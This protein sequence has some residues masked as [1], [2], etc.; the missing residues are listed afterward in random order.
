MNPSVSGKHNHLKVLGFNARQRRAF[1]NAVMRWGMPPPDAYNSQWLTRDLRGKSEK[2]FKAYVS[3]FMRHLC[4]PDNPAQKDEFADRVPKEGLNRQHVL[5]RIGIMSLIRKKVQEFETVNGLWSMP[6][7]QTQF[8]KQL[9]QDTPSK[10]ESQSSSRTGTPNPSTPNGTP[11]PAANKDEDAKA[12]VEDEKPAVNGE[13]TE[14]NHVEKAEPMETDE[15]KEKSKDENDQSKTETKTKP[16]E[17][18][19]SAVAKK[20]FMFNIADGGF[21]ELHTLWLNEERA[22]CP[23]REYEIWHRRHDY[24]LLAGIVT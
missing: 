21:T 24:W 3:L 5:T 14:N 1:Y 10:V 6:E 16:V 11:K 23:G 18:Q 19:P 20:K 8:E 12:A 2:V 7:V 17:E 22:A 13:A 9:N 4:E 15:V